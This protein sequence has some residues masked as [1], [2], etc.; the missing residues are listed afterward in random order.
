MSVQPDPCLTSLPAYVYA[1]D[2]TTAESLVYTGGAIQPYYY[3]E[4]GAVG[5]ELVAL[6]SATSSF[7]KLAIV[8]TNETNAAIQPVKRISSRRPSVGATGCRG[9]Y[10]ESSPHH[11]QRWTAFVS[12]TSS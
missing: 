12:P 4:A 7:P 9:E 6:D 11:D 1:R 3:S 10:L 5:L 2:F 8:L